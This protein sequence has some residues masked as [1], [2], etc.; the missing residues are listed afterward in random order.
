MAAR[1]KGSRYEWTWGGINGGM[2]S[3]RRLRGVWNDIGDR[4][5]K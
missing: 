2:G 1:E 4:E 3:G 5:G